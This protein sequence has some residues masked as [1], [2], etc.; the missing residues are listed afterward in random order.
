MK[1]NHAMRIAVLLIGALW[2][3]GAALGTT[4]GPLYDGDLE[5]QL[6]HARGVA[7]WVDEPLSEADFGTGSQ[8]F[9]GEW[10]FGT[11]VMGAI[12]HGQVAHEHPEYRALAGE[13]MERAIDGALSREGRAFDRAAWGTDPLDDI[14]TR[15]AHVAYLG[16]LDLAL[17][18]HR[19]V[20]PE[21]KF[22]ELEE[23]ITRHLAGLLER[24]ATGLVETYPGEVYPVDNAAFIGALGVHDAVTGEDHRTLIRRFRAELRGRYI[25][26][27]T[28]LLYQSVARRDGRPVD[29][30]RGSGTAL[31][32]YFLAYADPEL[33][34]QLWSAMR[35]E[36]YRQGLGF[37]A[38]REYAPGPGGQ[39]DIDSGPVVL[40][41]GVSATGFAIGAARAHGDRD[42]YRSLYATAAL[43]GAPTET[44]DLTSFALGGPIGDAIM[45]AMLTAPRAVARVRS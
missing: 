29:A 4:A 35:R 20:D 31:A 11:Y 39:G 3:P 34:E 30:A 42:A 7:R 22:I 10:L 43:F 21:S 33:S 18:L 41:L 16:Y 2:G 24:S 15:R 36:L 23:S 40:G 45:F 37:G 8:R 28:G 1:T 17:A 38:M 14:G 5:T 6:A 25:S 19:Q 32:T 44:G 26:A 9:D 12:G 27:E 13:R